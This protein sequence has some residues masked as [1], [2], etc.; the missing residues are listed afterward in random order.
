M[1]LFSAAD[2]RPHIGYRNTFQNVAV[3]SSRVPVGVTRLIGRPPSTFVGGRRP[4][5]SI[6][7]PQRAALARIWHEDQPGE[8]RRDRFPW[9]VP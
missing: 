9:S 5:S 4:G 7:I 1:L 6:Q 3:A 8:T 2:H